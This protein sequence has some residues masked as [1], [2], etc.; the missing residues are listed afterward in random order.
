MAK[1]IIWIGTS[2]NYANATLSGSLFLMETPPDNPA[3]YGQCFAQVDYSANDWIARE[4]NILLYFLSFSSLSL[5][6]PCIVL[7]ILILVYTMTIHFHSLKLK[8]IFFFILDLEENSSVCCLS[9]LAFKGALVL[10][11]F[12]TWG[13]YVCVFDLQH[14]LLLAW[15]ESFSFTTSHLHHP[16]TDRSLWKFK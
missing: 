8:L 1:I 16:G 6:I 15:N 2:I 3:A 10:C 5:K 9:S 14:T 11:S 7:P 4:L 12:C 13:V